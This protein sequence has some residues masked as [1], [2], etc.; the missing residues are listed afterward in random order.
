MRLSLSHIADDEW[1][2]VSWG[3]RAARATGLRRGTDAV[4]GGAAGGNRSIG[5][6]IDWS[7]RVDID[8]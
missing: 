4:A 6:P 3:E 7:R 2:A 1:R 8:L 5:S